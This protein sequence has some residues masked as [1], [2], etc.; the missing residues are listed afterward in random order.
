[1]MEMPVILHCDYTVMTVTLFQVCEIFKV[2]AT[3]FWSIVYKTATVKLQE[4]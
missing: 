2:L 4:S 1:M 3:Q